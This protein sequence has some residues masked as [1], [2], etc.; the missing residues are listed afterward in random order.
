MNHRNIIIP[1]S[2]KQ[3]T[4]ELTQ[5]MDA[6]GVDLEAFLNF[7]MQNYTVWDNEE[8]VRFSRYE[9]FLKQSNDGCGQD[10]VAVD[11]WH[12]WNDTLRAMDEC[13]AYF[14]NQIDYFLRLEGYGPPRWPHLYFDRLIGLDLYMSI[15]P[16]ET[17]AA[18]ADARLS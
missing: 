16:H 5:R 7:V 2:D 9:W 18:Y 12:E 11:G 15:L 13:M 17:G 3:F 1:I 8:D 14:K 4:D 6:Y 10:V